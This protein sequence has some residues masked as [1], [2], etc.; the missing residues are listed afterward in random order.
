MGKGKSKAASDRV[1]A[2]KRRGEAFEYRIAGLSYS[3]IADK[4]GISTS[5]A[6]SLVAEALKESQE[7]VKDLANRHRQIQHA[8]IEKL[9][10]AL[11]SDAVA[12]RSVEERRRSIAQIVKL[13]DRQ[14]KLWGM[15]APKLVEAT[16]KNLQ[17]VDPEDAEKAL[18]KAIENFKGG[19]A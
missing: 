10:A 8:R 17:E 6:H 3:K 2:S 15:D 7:S 14:A 1:R 9:V 13:L 5:R 16:V 4:L 12:A 18:L 19:V 11:W